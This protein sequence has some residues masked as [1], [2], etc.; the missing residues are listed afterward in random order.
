MP[1]KQLTTLSR[2]FAWALPRVAGCAALGVVLLQSPAAKAHF[3]LLAPASWIEE[4]SLGNPQKEPPCGGENEGSRTGLLTT[5]RAGATITV[6][7]QET[8]GH[9]GHFRIAVATDRKDF[10]DPPVETT[11]GD[12]VSGVSIDAMVMDPPAYPVLADGLFRRDLVIAPQEE[13]FSTQVRLPDTTCER[14]TLQL[15]Q[16]MG[17]HIPNYFYHHCADIRIVAASENVPDEGLVSEPGTG[18]GNGTMNTAPAEESNGGCSLVLPGSR[19]AH[20]HVAL[21]GLGL[22]A[23][24]WSRRRR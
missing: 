3:R 16:F 10:I 2:Q 12:G 17:S 19:R 6:A 9:P 1:S 21:L 11:N 15:I 14:C 20:S 18:A 8:V 13:P 7:W 24:L 22:G 23:A 4:D 5:Y